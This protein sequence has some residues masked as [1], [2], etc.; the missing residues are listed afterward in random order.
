MKRTVSFDENMNELEFKTTFR[1]K[2]SLYCSRVTG[3]L[4]LL[5]SCYW[6]LD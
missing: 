4:Y 3:C 1:E 2:I 5:F 6:C